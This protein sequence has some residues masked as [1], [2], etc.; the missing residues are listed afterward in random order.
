MEAKKT[1]GFVG[2]LLILVVGMSF[3][4]AEVIFN[5]TELSGSA[6]QGDS[7]SLS[8]NILNNYSSTMNTLSFNFSDLVSGSNV[9]DFSNLGVPLINSTTTIVGGNSLDVSLDIQV[10][11]NQPV[12]TYTGEIEL[13]GDLGSGSLTR[14]TVNI[15]LVVS[16]PPFEFCEQGENGTLTIKNFYVDNL[17]NGGDEEW[18]PLDE[19]EIEVEVEN[20]G[21]DKVKDVVVEI[22]IL[23]SSGDDVTNDFDLDEEII[24][25]K[26]LDE[27]EE[28]IA[29]FVINAV[30]AD[31]VEGYYKLYFKAYSEDDEA[32]ACVSSS[33]DFNDVDEEYHKIEF[34]REDDQAIIILDDDLF[35]QTIADSC[36]AE[37]IAVSLPVYNIGNVK[38]DKV[39]VNLYSFELGIDESF[40]IDNLKSGK[41]RDA[42]FFVN[43]PGDL[44]KSNYFLQVVTHF[45]YDEDEDELDLFSYDLNSD[46]DLGENYRIRVDVLDCEIPEPTVTANLQTEPFVDGEVSVKVLI[47]NNGKMGNFV[48][49]LS[50]LE[51]WA[52]IVSVEPSSLTI[53]ENSVGE[54]TLRFIPRV[55][56][57]Q[58][59]MI[60]SVIDGETF[61]QSVSVNIEE[62]PGFF[63]SLGDLAGYAIIGII[64]LAILIL[65]TLIAK[66]S[67]RKSPVEF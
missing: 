2:F 62:V 26:N 18:E 65:L 29:L 48:I 28:D 53:D 34:I 32:L 8:L 49:S 58:T 30:P 35:S 10:P 31:L 27:N 7:V 13:F 20:E 23:D 3:V 12:G 25:L 66:I 41:R 16:Q 45:D 39:L 38:E 43:L 33:N 44:D 63:S 5:P 4:S 22:M 52:D 9:L 51:N 11:S 6:D 47:R 57:L 42:N 40:L 56:G 50:E 59:F 24:D 36:D 37:N 67:R 55:E 14:G 64:A 15:T 1:F 21:A 19:I 60:N 17:G 54:V 46:D 61:T